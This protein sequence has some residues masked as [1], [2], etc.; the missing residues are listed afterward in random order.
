MFLTGLLFRTFLVCF[1]MTQIHLPR[2]GPGPSKNYSKDVPQTCLK[3]G[4]ME[5]LSRFQ[6]SSQVI[7]VFVKLIKA[8]QNRKFIVLSSLRMVSVSQPRSAPGFYGEKKKRQY[9]Y[10]MWRQSLTSWAEC[11]TYGYPSTTISYFLS[12]KRLQRIFI[13]GATGAHFNLFVSI[14]TWKKNQARFSTQNH[15]FCDL[16][17]LEFPERYLGRND[18][19][20]SHSKQLHI[21]LE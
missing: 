20:R 7:W 11:Q 18:Q 16:Y 19:I 12:A 17:K 5:A 6:F 14:T 15:L 3:A 8:N 13:F 4:L 9:L 1:L 2:S 21:F 10:R